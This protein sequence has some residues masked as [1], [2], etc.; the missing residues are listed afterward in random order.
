MSSLSFWYGA[1][2]AIVV[3]GILFS[4]WMGIRSLKIPI[5]CALRE[6]GKLDMA[7]IIKALEETESYPH[8]VPEFLVLPTCL[9]GIKSGLIEEWGNAIIPRYV[10]SELGK[11]FLDQRDW[12]R[13]K[14][15]FSV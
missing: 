1:V 12:R 14:K 5:L 8:F 11:S 9:L 3:G 6:R 7:G 2:T 4:C 15:K 13:G 10:L